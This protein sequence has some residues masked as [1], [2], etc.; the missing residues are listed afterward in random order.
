MVPS[1]QFFTHTLSSSTMKDGAVWYNSF[2]RVGATGKSAVFTF[3]MQK[4]EVTR[5]AFSCDGH[6][7]V[8]VSNSSWQLDM[9]NVNKNLRGMQI[10]RGKFIHFHLS[11]TN[12][13][14]FSAWMMIKSP[15]LSSLKQSHCCPLK[16]CIVC[17]I[18][19]LWVVNVYAVCAMS[20]KVIH[21]E[22]RGPWA[23][24]TVCNVTSIWQYYPAFT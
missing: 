9:E 21:R 18:P 14:E 19:L 23:W 22:D 10:K 16:I 24:S 5:K 12:D 2:T 17:L 8:H 6:R 11:V 1:M 20:N 13:A 7:G 3:G 15:K 4:L